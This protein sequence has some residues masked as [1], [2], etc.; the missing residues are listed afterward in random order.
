MIREEN[1]K[2]PR[3]QWKDENK[4]KQNKTRGGNLHLL[5]VSTNY[6]SSAFFVWFQ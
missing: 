2:S 4:T 1:T 6:S 3:N 5:Y